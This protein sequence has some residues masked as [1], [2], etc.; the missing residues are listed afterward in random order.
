MPDSGGVRSALTSRPPRRYILT[1]DNVHDVEDYMKELLDTSDSRVQLFLSHFLKQWKQPVIKPLANSKQSIKEPNSSNNREKTQTLPSKLSN[2]TVS[3]KNL[4]SKFYQKNKSGE[5]YFGG[6]T[7]KT[8]SKGAK[9]KVPEPVSNKVPEPVSNKVPEPVSNKVPTSK[10]S[11]SNGTQAKTTN[12]NTLKK[13]KKFVSLYSNEGIARTVV[14]LPG[15]HSCDCQALKHDLVNNCIECGRI[16]C[17]QEGAGPCLFCGNL[18]C[19]K[20][21]EKILAEGTK[22][23]EKLRQI[24]MKD[25][26]KVLQLINNQILRLSTENGTCSQSAELSKAVDYKN[27]LLDYDNTSVKRTQ[28]ID[29]DA[30]YFSS[31]S[32]W[33]SKSEREVLKRREDELRNIRFQSRRDRKITFDFAGRR[34]V[35][36]EEEAFKSGTNMYEEEKMRSQT[37]A[38]EAPSSVISK[39]NDIPLGELVNPS[40]KVAAPKFVQPKDKVFECSFSKAVEQGKRSSIRLQDREIQEMRDEGYCLSMHQPYASLLIAGIKLHEGRTWYTS[41][42][43]KLWIASTAKPPLQDEIDSLESSY[44]AMYK[45]TD[46][47]FPKFYQPGCLLGCVD[48]VDCL[49]QGDYRTQFPDGES[50]SPYVFICQNPKELVVNFPIKGKHKIFKLDPHIHQGAKKGL[51]KNVYDEG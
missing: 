9:P 31:D 6:T 33:L 51:R 24:L 3:P 27:R 38:Q 23:S 50:G 17:A 32:Q 12:E 43:G 47:V 13:K 37:Q 45:D 10:E 26:D 5:D 15:R 30:D 11:Q 44:H 14:K 22:K 1:I 36:E 49:E 18:V 39:N 48:L 16:V 35:D 34:I 46:I 25:T 7:K 2:N 20:E 40:I 28:V 41:H 19:S 29:D 21:Q 4:P 8:K 42:R